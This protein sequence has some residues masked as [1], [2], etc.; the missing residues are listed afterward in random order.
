[1]S[2]PALGIDLGTSKTA[3]AVCTTGRKQLW[4][5]SQ[6]HDAALPAPPGHAEQDA[7]RILDSAF[8]LIRQIPGDLR[9][10]L[11]AV[12]I[13]GQMH[14]VVLHDLNARPLSPLVTWQDARTPGITLDGRAIPAGFGLATLAWWAAHD[15]L[16][17]PRAATVHGLL[18][19]RLCGRD[20]APID[21]TDLAAWGGAGLPPGVPGGIMP[22]PVAHGALVGTVLPGF[23]LPA[24]IPVAAP[25]GDNQASLRATLSDP[26]SEIALTIGT[27]C[28]LSAVVPLGQLTEPLPHGG[29]RRPFDN[30][31]ELI[32]AAP[33][34]GGA[35][36]RWLAERTR[37]WTRDMGFQP[38]P[39]EEAFAKLDALGLAASGALVFH[40][41]L[42]GERH[43]P[44]LAASLTGLRLNNGSLGEIARAVAHAI[45]ANARAMLPPGLFQ[46][47]LRAIASGNALRRSALLRRE[48]EAA[49]GLP[50]LLSDLREEAATGAALVAAALM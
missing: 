17:A 28:Q 12:G 25:L 18:T 22:E 2:R 36:W 3:L 31:R 26:A 27:G 20:R 5:A 14:G 44:A 46:G 41:H 33:R 8:H 34:A 29:E 30:T 50:L 19:A 49:L 6:P 43:N 13:T 42:D 35:A 7:E 15:L 1:M 47:R 24:G 45:P 38:P 32:V 37:D 9:E 39:I 4:A 23:G 10:R 16:N 48:A 11:G 40:P 21:P